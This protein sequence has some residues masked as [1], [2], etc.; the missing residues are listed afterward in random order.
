M[1]FNDFH[2]FFFKASEGAFSRITR[3]EFKDSQMTFT[4]LEAEIIIRHFGVHN[5]TVGGV[6]TDRDLSKKSF[7][8]YPTMQEVNLNVVFP[9]VHKPELRIYF[10]AKRGTGFRPLQNEIFFI[11][12]NEDE[13][14]VIGAL[15]ETIW[16]SLGQVDIEDQLYQ[17]EIES[18]N[19]GSPTIN[20]NPAGRIIRR[21]SI[22][23]TFW[24]DPN[25]AILRFRETNYTCEID[26]LHLTFVAETTN[27][28]YVEAHHFIPIKFQERYQ[29]PLDSLSNVV[30]LCPNCHRGVHHGVIEHKYELISNIYAKRP[31]I[32][33]HTIQEIA[34][35]YNCLRVPET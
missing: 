24:R 14:L 19:I 18:I 30:S 28:Q 25:I 15:E 31:E 9:K 29:Y 13:R 1:E 35:L 5:I 2:K 10:A 3:T 21:S 34:E 33:I 12:I 6:Y 11:Y 17:D 23:N 7:L 20:V 32:Q 22:T 4:G 16:N 26:P 8:I 27:L